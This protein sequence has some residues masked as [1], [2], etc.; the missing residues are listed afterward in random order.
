MISAELGTGLRQ[1]EGEPLFEEPWQAQALA[2]A[3]LL[4]KSG[5]IAPETWTRTL[6]AELRRASA[7]GKPDDSATYGSAVLSVLEA[8]IISE[9]KVTRA[10]LARR[11][12]EWE[13]AY[14]ETPHGHP[15]Q[16]FRS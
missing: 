6:G 11:R 3:D 12:A 5:I 13:R 16:L 1:R 8:L 2:M 7:E 9:R 10:E 4:I 14:L 15:V